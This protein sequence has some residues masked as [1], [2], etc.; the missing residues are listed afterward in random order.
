MTIYSVWIVGRAGGLLYQKYLTD[1]HPKLSAN[2][3][4]I[5]ASTFQR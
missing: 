5:L 4:L 3:L 1:F 2:E